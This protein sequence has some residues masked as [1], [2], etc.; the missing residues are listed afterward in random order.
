MR[1]RASPLAPT[2]T[3][4][5]AA[6]PRLGLG[7]SI[8]LD[9]LRPDRF[10]HTQRPAGLP[11]Q[12]HDPRLRA[13]L[14]PERCSTRPV[15]VAPTDAIPADKSS[16]TASG[17]NGG[18][19]PRQRLAAPP[20]HPVSVYHDGLGRVR[21][22]VGRL[23]RGRS[24]GFTI[25]GNLVLLDLVRERVPD[26]DHYALLSPL[27]S[28]WLQQFDPVYVESRMF[29]THLMLQQGRMF[30]PRTAGG[31]N[32]WL[33]AFVDELAEFDKGR[34]DDMID[35]TAYAARVAERYWVPGETAEQ[36]RAWRDPAPDMSDPFEKAYAGTDHVVNFSIFR[37][38]ETLDRA[39][40]GPLV[41]VSRD[42]RTRE[43]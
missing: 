15:T 32:G 14:R 10:M 25:D 18:W 40:L 37:T 8:E 31:P 3:T 1:S 17:S 11:H 16:P 12:Q 35:V 7:N 26:T 4:E 38:D 27:R 2:E 36:E 39:V 9:L 22:N 13:P 28:R 43:F 20:P 42:P 33:D 23:D 24:V 19:D 6:R 34:H 5:L 30:L 41:T 21:E 29:G